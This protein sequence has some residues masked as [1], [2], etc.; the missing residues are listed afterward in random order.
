MNLQIRLKYWS[1]FL[2]SIMNQVKAMC[3]CWQIVM[4]WRKIFLKTFNFV[5]ISF[6]RSID[7]QIITQNIEH[8]EKD[9]VPHCQWPSSYPYFYIKLS[10]YFSSLLLDP[11]T[12]SMP[13]G[14]VNN[15]L[16]R[17]KV[18][19]SRNLGQVNIRSEIRSGHIW[20]RSRCRTAKMC[21][22]SGKE[23]RSQ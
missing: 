2:K 5:F 3:N 19:D 12:V 9:H 20:F 11:C 7:I 23:V 8:M 13:R 15:I 6:L 4:D 16:M 14:S 21:Q 10:I 22:G 18:K 17:S 1:N